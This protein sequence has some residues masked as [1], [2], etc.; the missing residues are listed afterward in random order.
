MWSHIAL[1]II[2]ILLHVSGAILAYSFG[3][4]PKDVIDSKVGFIASHEFDILLFALVMRAIIFG[5][6]DNL[7]KLAEWLH[8]VVYTSAVLQISSLVYCLFVAY[9]SVYIVGHGNFTNTLFESHNNDVDDEAIVMW[10]LVL[11]TNG[12]SLILCMLDVLEAQARSTTPRR[13]GLCVSV[14][15]C[16]K[17]KLQNR[18]QPTG[19]V[20]TTNDD[21]LIF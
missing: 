14:L 2:L 9:E 10:W 8:L 21:D 5:L 3:P 20:P 1:Q 4:T 16:C 18:V 12:V 11:F 6:F 17:P 7:V 13:F 19:A 15:K